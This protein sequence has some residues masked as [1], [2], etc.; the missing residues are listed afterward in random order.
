M[1][2]LLLPSR[3]TLAALVT[4]AVGCHPGQH[5]GTPGGAVNWDP[6]LLCH[7]APAGLVVVIPNHSFLKDVEVPERHYRS[8]VK[9]VLYAADPT[10]ATM[11]AITYFQQHDITYLERLVARSSLPDA[12]LAPGTRKPVGYQTAVV[13]GR[14]PGTAIWFS[15]TETNRPVKPFSAPTA[16]ML[17]LLRA[18]SK[19]ACYAL[20][21]QLFPDALQCGKAAE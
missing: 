20:H 10:D 7:C 5:P 11:T 2:C 4:L 13:G 6:C 19:E 18:D 14:E 21:N 16:T 9:E 8:V 15:P 3:Q 12:A 17:Q 1:E